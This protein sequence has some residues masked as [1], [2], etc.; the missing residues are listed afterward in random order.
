M[1]NKTALVTGGAKG[2]G[3]GIAEGFLKEGANVYVMDIKGEREN[4]NY[5][6]IDLTNK[7][8][9]E[10]QIEQF[11]LD[12]IVFDILVNCDGISL[13]E[14]SEDYS[15]EKWENRYLLI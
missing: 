14:P 10:K 1:E 5:I 2:N 4:I 6:E 11:E 9:L 13:S 15:F 7:D 8:I 3:D 12:G